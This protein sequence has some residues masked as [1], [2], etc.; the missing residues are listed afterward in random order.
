[1][2]RSGDPAVSGSGRSFRDAVFAAEELEETAK[3]AFLTKHLPLRRLSK[4]LVAELS[5]HRQK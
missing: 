4:H 1:M 3:L 5:Q 2:I